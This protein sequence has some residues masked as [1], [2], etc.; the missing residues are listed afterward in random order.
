MKEMMAGEFLSM[1]AQR[2]ERELSLEG[3]FTGCLLCSFEMCHD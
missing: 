2:R 1:N 3:V